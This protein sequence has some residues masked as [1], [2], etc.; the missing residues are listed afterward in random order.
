MGRGGLYAGL[1]L[2]VVAAAVGL[3]LW[4]QTGAIPDAAAPGEVVARV[5]DGAAS[6]QPRD[7]RRPAVEQ[8]RVPGVAASGEPDREA[9]E[10]A[11]VD[12]QPLDA[13]TETG[14]DVGEVGAVGPGPGASNEA[15][16]AWEE[17]EPGRAQTRQEIKEAIQ[18]M[19]PQVKV[20]YE[21]LLETF[22]DANGEIKLQFTIVGDGDASHI[23]LEKIGEESSLYDKN[24]HQCLLDELRSVSLPAWRG[25]REM[26]VTY[27]F[28]FSEGEAVKGP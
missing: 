17:S 6:P 8:R 3:W 18:E 23:D 12:V 21:R 2:L 19:K 4:Q 16:L 5:D 7:V 1:A 22:P 28:R 10:P 11:P 15:Q 9:P 14:G 13:G 26:K 27:P 20:C 25:G 24:L